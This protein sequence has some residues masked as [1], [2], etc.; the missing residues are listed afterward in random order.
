MTLR[1]AQAHFVRLSNE[2]QV[3]IQGLGFS[4]WIREPQSVIIDSSDEE[5]SDSN[6]ETLIKSKG[7]PKLGSP[8]LG[9]PKLGSPKLN[10]SLRRVPST[11]TNLSRD[12]NQ[13][14]GKFPDSPKR[15]HSR[16]GWSSHSNSTINTNSSCSMRRNFARTWS[17]E[18]ISFS[19]D[20]IEEEEEENIKTSS[21]LED[22]F[23]SSTFSTFSE[24]SEETSDLSTTESDEDSSIESLENLSLSD[25]SDRE[26]EK[27]FTRNERSLNKLTTNSSE[28]LSST[29]SF[30]SDSTSK[31]SIHSKEDDETSS[32]QEKRLQL[33]EALLASQSEEEVE[34]E[35]K[36]YQSDSENSLYK[37]FTNSIFSSSEDEGDSEEEVEYSNAVEVSKAFYGVSTSFTS[38]Q[39]HQDSK[40]HHSRQLRSK[41]ASGYYSSDSE[42]DWE[43]SNQN[44]QDEDDDDEEFET[45]ILGIGNI[46]DEISQPLSTNLIKPNPRPTT[47]A[48]MQSKINLPVIVAP[49][50]VVDKLLAKI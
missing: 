42:D 22:T 1:T 9:S 24:S 45:I 26:E 29:S 3:E 13:V 46:N 14:S 23:T 18:T 49:K 34:V 47:I 31:T 15:R 39:Y 36:E 33:S 41:R 4:H 32:T 50:V 43:F 19:H 44:G 8:K 40:F 6:D 48:E 11:L 28:S 12:F 37:G 20:N 21:D 5:D 30:E 2:H 35:K 16:G 38:S 10:S 27:V 7:S 25:E 17:G